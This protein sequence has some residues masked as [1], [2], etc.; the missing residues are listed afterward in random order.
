MQPG[1]TNIIDRCDHTAHCFSNQTGFLSSRNISSSGADE[2]HSPPRL[3]RKTALAIDRCRAG[4][5]PK[6]NLAI[7]KLLIQSSEQFWS[8]PTDQSTT[9]FP[10]E[11]MSNRHYLH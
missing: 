1:H 11:S 3:C 5:F 6:D 2:S 9:I 8:Y 4:R 10:N 7:C